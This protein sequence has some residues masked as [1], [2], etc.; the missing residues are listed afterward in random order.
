MELDEY[1]RACGLEDLLG[2]NSDLVRRGEYEA[3]DQNMTAALGAQWT[4]LVR[5][6][7]LVRKRRVTTILEFGCGWSTLV[8]AHALRMNRD[9]FSLEVR[10]VLRRS[11]AFELHVVDDMPNYLAVAKERLPS[12]LAELTVFSSSEVH[13]T[14]FGGRICTEYQTLPNICPDFVY[15]DAPSQYSVH[16]SRNGITTAHP[17]RVPMACDLLKIEHFLLPGTLIVVDGRT[18]NARFL[19]SNL[20]RSWRYEHDQEGDVHYL[21]LAEPPLGKYNRA[22]IEFCLGAEW[23]T[24][25]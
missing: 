5:L 8:L 7:Q 14:T 15:L 24:R 11:N 17:D 13:M 4:D 12:S 9:E 20:Q 1:V 16:G 18:A 2:P 3:V 19:R 22:Q 6:H 10:S 21:E 25:L 23:L